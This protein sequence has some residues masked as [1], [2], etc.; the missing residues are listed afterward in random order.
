VVLKGGTRE[1][2]FFQADV[3]NARIGLPLP[4]GV[5]ILGS[6]MPPSQESEASAL[7]NSWRSPMTALHVPDRTCN[8]GGGLQVGFSAGAT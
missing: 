5:S 8:W 4:G 2:F 6:A 7:P 3:V 1:I